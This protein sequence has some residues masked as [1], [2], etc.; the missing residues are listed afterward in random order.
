M[1]EVI[2]LFPSTR[3]VGEEIK[4]MEEIGF[5]KNDI[6]VITKEGHLK[7]ILGCEPNRIVMNYAILGALLGIAVYGIFV[8]VAVWCDCAIYPIKQLI[9][10][11]IVL[12][13]IIAG[14]LFGGILGIFI[15]LAEYEKGTHLYIQGVKIGEKV[16]A[17]KTDKRNVDKA[18]KILTQIGCQGV[19]V[20]PE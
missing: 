10:V 11:E 15:G 16:F 12:A 17:L 1:S 14:A 18:V 9:V 8:L 3:D 13:G 4:E 19:Q 2:G 20:L 6:R 7:K 5:T